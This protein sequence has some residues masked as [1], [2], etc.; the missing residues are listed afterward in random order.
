RAFARPW[1]G[2]DC[3]RPFAQLA[4]MGERTRVQTRMILAEGEQWVARAL[5][6]REEAEDQPLAHA[7]DGK[8]HF[9]RA[10]APQHALEHQRAIGQDLA[11][12]PRDLLDAA[13][14]S[15][16][17]RPANALAE[18]DAGAALDAVAVHDPQRIL[19]QV[20]VELGER[21][22]GSTDGVERARIAG[23]EPRQRGK[24]RV[25]DIYGPFEL[26]ARRIDE[27]QP[28]ERQSGSGRGFR[29]RNV[30]QLE[31]AAAE[32]AGDP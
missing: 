17:F 16:F 26:V 19:A 28:A 31:A 1:F 14:V 13:D 7:E 25:N 18:V 23:R 20:H 3:V 22:P 27:P 30:D 21:A 32:V 6:R 4:R 12:C 24:A 8:H 5:G 10:Y 29:T 2:E 11:A 9:L 15:G